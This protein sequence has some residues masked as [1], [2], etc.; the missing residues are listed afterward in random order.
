ML[1]RIEEL[2]RKHQALTVGV[3]R[4]ELHKG[5]LV[6]IGASVSGSSDE[7]RIDHERTCG[8]STCDL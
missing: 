3:R 5:E 1:S 2:A 8:E 6:Q 4:L 7:D